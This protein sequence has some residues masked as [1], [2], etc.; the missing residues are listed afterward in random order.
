MTYR[1]IDYKAVRGLVP[2]SR[3]VE[4]LEYEPRIRRG[5]RLRGACML[6]ECGGSD[7]AFRI[8]LERSLWYCFSCRKGGDQIVL[9]RLIRGCGNYAAAIEMC[10]LAGHPV[11]YRLTT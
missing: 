10:T 7:L 3:I 8:D 9:W 2:I 6:A 4:W 11:P 1:P 5:D